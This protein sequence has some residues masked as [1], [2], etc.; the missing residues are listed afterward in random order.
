MATPKG[1]SHHSMYDL[2]AVVEDIVSPKDPKGRA[3]SAR[4]ARR[5]P[6]SS[7]LKRMATIS[8]L[9]LPDGYLGPKPGENLAIPRASAPKDSRAFWVA[10]KG[11]PEILRGMFANLPDHYDETYMH[12]AMNG[13]RV[14]ALGWKWMSESEMRSEAEAR[15]KNHTHSTPLGKNGWYREVSRDAIESNLQFGGF[16]VFHCPL[17]PDTAS[18][19]MELHQS[20]HRVR[21]GT[22]HSR[23]I[24]NPID[25]H[26][27]R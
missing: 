27:Y 22:T 24:S 8:K 14:I 7:A 18:A 5:F 23:L 2:T 1:Y 17:K 25:C 19:I 21:R 16:L 4:I 9:E 12:F 13:S 20:M 10:V 15:H 11:A 3:P 26:D 6:F